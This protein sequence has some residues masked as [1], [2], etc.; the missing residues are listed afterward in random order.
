MIN[1]LSVSGRKLIIL[2]TVSG[3]TNSA[4]IE[5]AKKIPQ[6]AGYEN[7]SVEDVKSN[8]AQPARQQT[9]IL[10]AE[11]IANRFSWTLY[12]ADGK[13]IGGGNR[14][15]FDWYCN[16]PIVD[17]L[18]LCRQVLSVLDSMRKDGDVTL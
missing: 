14:S 12:D 5:A 4:L 17:N 10:L 8:H 11:I 3:S 1:Y 16:S 7:F 18:V 6:F 13:T 15:W 2:D 9:E